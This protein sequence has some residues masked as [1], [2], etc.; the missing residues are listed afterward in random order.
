MSQQNTSQPP[1]IERA[2]FTVPEASHYLALKED[3]IRDL[4]RRKE[5]AG[6]RTRG[7]NRGD[8]R[9]SRAA[10]DEWIERQTRNA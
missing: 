2:V 10:C 9:V 7:P 6:W 8:W 5:L 3:S 4:L 1:S